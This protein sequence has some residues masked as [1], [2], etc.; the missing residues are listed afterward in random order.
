[1]MSSSGLPGRNRVGH[2]VGRLVLWLAA[3]FVLAAATAQT[4]WAQTY[5]VLHGFTGGVDGDAPYTGLT[6]DAAGDLY[7]TTSGGGANGRGVV[8]KLTHIGSNWTFGTI[9]SFAGGSD[10][11]NPQSRIAIA[12]DGALYGAT[13]GGGGQ[14]CSTYGCG[15]IYRLRPPITVPKTVR[16]T[17]TEIVLHTFNGVDGSHPQGDLTFDDA[18]SIYGTTIGGGDFNWGTVYKLARSGQTWTHSIL[19]SARNDA[20]GSEPYGGVIFDKSGNLYGV[21]Q[22]SQGGLGTAFQLTPSGSGWTEHTIHSFNFGGDNGVEPIGGLIMDSLGNLFG[23]TLYGGSFPAAG[24][25]YELMPSDSGWQYATIHSFTDGDGGPVD[26]LIMDATG[27]LYG[28]ALTGGAFGQGEVF[29]LTPSGGG[30]IHTSL[31]DFCAA[32]F[33]CPDGA[34]PMSALVFDAQGHIYGTTSRGGA[35]GN[36]VVF[37][38]AP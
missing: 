16:T 32:G 7:G 18:G 25:V 22:F 19:F 17:W 36:G 12:S 6:M 27:N 31:H 10:G 24:A 15:T 30:W 4:A 26:K 5:T 37:Q 28:T 29:K 14:G 3:I 1:M 8:F 34:E 23:G 33:P 20:D 2:H 13:D 35:S 11:S 38:I 21:C 9:Y